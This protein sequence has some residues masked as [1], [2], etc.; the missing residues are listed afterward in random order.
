MTWFLRIIRSARREVAPIAFT[1]ALAITATFASAN[2]IVLLTADGEGHTSACATCPNH[3]GL[4]GLDRRATALTQARAAASAAGGSTLLLDAGNWLAGPESVSTRGRS[5]VS[6]Y[7][8]IGY[9][10]VHLTPKDLYWGKADTLALLK[11]AKFAVVSANLL[12]EQSGV[13]LASPFVVKTVDGKKVA[14]LGVS[15]V[16]AGLALLP[17]VRQQLAGIR[18]RAPEEAIDE[19]FPKA[20]AAADHVLVLYQG[21]AKTLRSIRSKLKGSGAWILASG[22]RPENGAHAGEGEPP[23][24]AAHEHGKSLARATLGGGEFEV[25]QVMVTPDLAPDAAMQKLL[26]EYA[27]PPLALRPEPATEPSAVAATTPTA[28]AVTAAPAPAEAPPAAPAPGAPALGLSKLGARGPAVATATPATTPPEVPATLPAAAAPQQPAP[29]QRVT[30][31]QPH[32]SKGLQGVGL[33]PAQVNAAIDRGAKFL[34]DHLQVE[35]QKGHRKLGESYVNTDIL[36]SLALVHAGWH[37][38][39][40]ELDKQIREF[41]TKIDPVT[42][43]PGTYENGVLCMLIEDYGNPTLLPL[44]QRSTRRLIE[45]Q[46]EKGTWSYQVE[47]K[48][49]DFEAAAGGG[50]VLRALGGRDPDARM[51]GVELRRNTEWARGKDGDNSVSQFAA[52]GLRAASRCGFKAPADAWKRLIE[53]TRRR[54][55]VDGGWAYEGPSGAYGSMTCAGVSMLSIARHELGESDPAAD[56]AIERGLA[57]LAG[58]FTVQHNPNYERSYHYYYLYSLER[59]GRLLDTEFIGP[60]EWYP[61]GA[62]YL[63]DNQRPDGRWVESRD[64]EDPVLPVSFALL[65]LTRATATLKVGPMA[66]GGRGNLSTVATAPPPSRVHIILDASGSMLSEMNGRPKLDVARD[67]LAALADDLPLGTQLGLRVYGH[68]KRATDPEADEDSNLELPITPLN[69][70]ALRAL[71]GS[72]RARGKTPL[73]HSLKQ[74][75]NDVIPAAGGPVTVLLLTDG[76]DD[77][78]SRGGAVEAAAGLGKIR[79]VTLHVVGFDIDP[80]AVPQLREI[81]R[82]GN[83]EYWSADRPE[84]LKAGLAEVLLGAPE[85]FVVVDAAGT[86]AGEGRFGTSISLPDRKYQLL[87]RFGGREFTSDFWINTGRTT[88]VIFDSAEALAT[89]HAPATAPAAVQQT[90][91]APP[92]DPPA[93]PRFCTSCGARLAATGKFCTSC[94]AAIPR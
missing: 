31:R 1:V 72:I 41:L 90:P 13:P 81:A 35:L 50:Q 51:P 43:M 29:P 70:T 28:P 3:R 83:G 63:V 93:K 17:H 69:P 5:I 54:Q 86:V 37:K 64:D 77:T 48:P 89:L 18:M 39:H 12:D 32:K 16:P 74:A 62:R 91:A 76:G 88:A 75:V 57:W 87:T 26:T 30:A 79:G 42:A 80:P 58:N 10:V 24:M 40:P 59:V 78:A 94:G 82:V 61:L 9:D 55:T 8:A 44:L 84:D 20:K 11:D 56:E 22:V 21:R 45:Q 19:W 23:V 15:E 33:T 47:L 46:G 34:Y 66:R 25:T 7:D 36:A 2:P 27:P 14:I 92:A 38:K 65:F 49:T 85:K 68:R 53:E 67:A 52:L 4:G 73:T 6:A 60:H 71:L